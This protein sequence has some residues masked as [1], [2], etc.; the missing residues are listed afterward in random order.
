MKDI[1]LIPLA[2]E[3]LDIVR[4]WRNSPEVSQY[5][6]KDENITREQQEKWFKK[7]QQ[8]ESKKYWIIKYEGEELG[9]ANLTE[10]DKWNSKCY[11][12]FYLGNTS[13][14]GKGIGAKIE[15][16]VLNYVFG[17]LKLNKLCGEVFSFNE[18]VVQ[19]HEKF[20]FR[21]EGY[22][23][24]HIQKNNRF[25]DIVVIGLLSSEWKQ[26]KD[27]LKTKIYG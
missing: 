26:L 1:E 5:M 18:K 16:N 20:G 21:R 24:N 6:Y 15:Y 10:I 2:E 8:D 4:E 14:R 25:H 11:W 19:M 23:R 12:G 22:L 17:E 27:S 3:D 9:V 13:I 7:V